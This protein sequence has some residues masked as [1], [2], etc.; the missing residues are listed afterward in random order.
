MSVKEL[1]SWAANRSLNSW[2]KWQWPLYSLKAG[3]S[4]LK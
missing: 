4:L 3:N 2:I 1:E